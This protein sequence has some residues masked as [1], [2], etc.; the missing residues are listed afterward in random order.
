M[1]NQDSEFDNLAIA[2]RA[3][4]KSNQD[5]LLSY[6]A[7]GKPIPYSDWSLI[8][9]TE[10]TTDASQRLRFGC[11]QVRKKAVL[12]KQGI[13]Y[14]SQTL[15]KAEQRTIEKFAKAKNHDLITTEEFIEQ[16]FFYHV[17]DLSAL[18]IGFNLPF[19]L[20]RFALKASPARRKIRGGFSF[21]FSEKKERPRIQIKHINSKS[22]LIQFTIPSKQETPRNWRK[23]NQKVMPHRGYFLDVK[24]IACALLSGS[25]SL[26][27]LG[28]HLKTE[29]QKHKTDEHGAKL[30]AQYLTYAIQDVQVT[31]ECFLKLR[32]QYQ[33]YGLE[34]PINKV[35]S[36]A[37]IG[38]ACLQQ[39]GIKP[40]RELQPDFPD[41]LLGIILSAYYGGRSEVRI[42]REITR[43]LYCDF[44]SMY[45]TV[46]TLMELWKFVV[47]ER[48]DWKDSTLFVQSL[49]SSITLAKLRKLETW[50]QLL[51]LVQIQPDGD[52]LPVRAKY[53]GNQSTIGLNHLTS[54]QP[55]WYTVAD[56]IASK[57]LTG[58]IPKIV[59]AISFHPVDI[60]SELK[61][62]A[63]AGNK[64]YLVEPIEDDFY[65]RLIELRQEVKGKLK[66]CSS[67][68][69]D[70]FETDQLAL[71][72]LANATSYGIF[73][74]INVAEKDKKQRVTCYGYDET[75]FDTFIKNM[76]EPGKYFHPLL[77]TLITGA[78]RLM[79]AIAEALTEKEQI[80]W[81][82]CD[83][84]SMALAQPKQ[85]KDEEFL[86][87][88]HNIS[89]WF[90][91]LNPYF[92]KSPLFKTEDVN[93]SGNGKQEEPLYCYAISAKRYA[94]FNLDKDKRLILRK[95]SGHGL[96]HF[97]S[98][99][100]NYSRPENIPDPLV[101]FR[102]LG[103]E[104]WQ[105][106]LWYRVVEAALTGH[107]DQVE[108]RNLPGFN[109]PAVSRYTA[110]SPT[111]LSWFKEYNRGKSY[112]DQVKPFNFLLAGQTSNLTCGELVQGKKS[113]RKLRPITPFDRDHQRAMKNCFDRDSGIRIQIN[114]L[115]TYAE[116]LPQYHLQPE[117]KFENG[118]YLNQGFTQRK[119]I[120]A[121][122]II[123]I[124]KEANRMEEQFYL[125]LEEDS[126][127][128]YGMSN[129]QFAIYSDSVLKACKKI[130]Q[131]KLAEA[132]SLSLKHISRILQKKSKPTRKA[133]LSI[134]KGLM[135]LLENNKI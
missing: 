55:L 59:K 64:D 119:Q 17:Y 9:D 38:K 21:V 4:A 32:N 135:I 84:D 43:V 89:E 66:S 30:T 24:T 98:P 20:S 53:D 130:S 67:S 77:A 71:K 125:G 47:A 72:I 18:C 15:S 56:C 105:Y 128:I 62:L 46:C 76:E 116:A 42:R 129:K 81:A 109:L 127:I 1:K 112:A 49:L 5:Q 96:G 13:F 101:S 111:L 75:P 70:K 134:C 63:I 99:L 23:K 54:E 117:S 44:L 126:E 39:M 78:A 3:Y 36:E 92:F 25:W 10:T 61:P 65:R 28:E 113:K 12:K 2:V 100:E 27:S 11:Y 132:S 73:V 52:T 26:Q 60:Q 7:K 37:S 91:L 45:P 87:K 115:K 108:I 97:L 90:D 50:K 110:T 102:G 79:L 83:T 14:D 16:V 34:T 51:T 93:F 40:W 131:R 122:A 68:E 19:D 88:A 94:L 118:D 33:T 57:L 107:P 133:L 124:G 95:A 103:V 8:F 86:A 114:R 123:N 120:K 74:E 106:C 41:E 31:W 35:F 58:R 85:M 69:K 80:N 6:Q 82:F 29:N 104:A 48:I 22:S 121:D